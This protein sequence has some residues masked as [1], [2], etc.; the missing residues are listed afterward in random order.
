MTNLPQLIHDGAL[1]A[2]VVPLTY[3]VAVGAAAIT[4]LVAPTPARRRAAREV[5]ALLLRRRE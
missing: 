3:A 4:A 5:L 1:A 2:A